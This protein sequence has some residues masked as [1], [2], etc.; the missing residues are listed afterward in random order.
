MPCLYYF[1]NSHDKRV[2]GG[3]FNHF[4]N[5]MLLQKIKDIMLIVITK[6]KKKNC[7]KNKA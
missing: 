1:N 2:D 7:K 5:G 4:E 6:K 3:T